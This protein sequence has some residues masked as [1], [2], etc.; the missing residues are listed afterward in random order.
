MKGELVPHG[1]IPVSVRLLLQQTFHGAGGIALVRLRNASRNRLLTYHHFNA[2]TVEP[3][4]EQCQHLRRRY[5]PV[6]L[7]DIADSLLAGKQLPRN[8][9]SITVDDGYRDFYQYAYPALKRY[10]ISAT[11]FLMTDFV[12]GIVWP[13]WDHIRYAF[14]HTAL[15]STDLRVADDV[16]LHLRFSS[17]ICRERACRETEE[18]MKSVPNAK[19]LEFIAKLPDLLQV[20]VPASPPEP[21]ETIDLDRD[22]RDG[23]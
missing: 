3:F 14:E 21:F 13:W 2:S 18:A 8:S 9:V 12:D 7:D 4:E 22:P 16:E 17:S 10:G 19:R 23:V 1:H 11:V 5:T 6:T 20:D 15:E